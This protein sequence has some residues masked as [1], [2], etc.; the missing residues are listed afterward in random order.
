MTLAWTEEMRDQAAW[1]VREARGA[2]GKWAHTACMLVFVWYKELIAAIWSEE[3][4]ISPK[5]L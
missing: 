4:R 2:G 3:I 1:W 5:P